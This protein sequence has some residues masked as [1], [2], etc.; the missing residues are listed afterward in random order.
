MSSL[1]IRVHPSA[2]R[3]GILLHCRCALIWFRRCYHHAN[4]CY[5]YG[6]ARE[7]WLGIG[8]KNAGLG[9]A[10]GGRRRGG[11]GGRERLFRANA[12]NEEEQVV[13]ESRAVKKVDSVRGATPA[14]RRERYEDRRCTTQPRT[15]PVSPFYPTSRGNA[16]QVAERRRGGISFGLQTI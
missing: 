2:L 11:G 8:K 7:W 9:G 5:G 3:H 10:G 16:D 13:F 4:T 12:M 1:V 14:C 15:H 6:S